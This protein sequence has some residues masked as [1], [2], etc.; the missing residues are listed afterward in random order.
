MDEVETGVRCIAAGIRDDSGALVAGLSLSM[1]AERFNP[2]RSKEV[3]ET[4]KAISAALGWT[5]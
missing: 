5:A 2:D 4:A 1:P 3:T